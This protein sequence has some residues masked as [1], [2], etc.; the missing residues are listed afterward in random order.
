MPISVVAADRFSPYSSGARRAA[1]VSTQQ[2][3]ERALG[4]RYQI[5]RLLGWGAAGIVY[6]AR[7]RALHRTVVLKLL[8]PELSGD[9][10]ARER[11][12]REARTTAQLTHPGIVPVHAFGELEPADGTARKHPLLYMV[13]SYVG[14]GS[15]ADRLATGHPLPPAELRRLLVDLAAALEYAHREGVVH[16]DVKPENVLLAVD[17]AGA[18]PRPVLID[19][20]VAAFPTRDAGPAFAAMAAGTPAFMAPEQLLGDFELDGRSDVYALGAIGYLALAGQLPEAFPSARTPLA[21]LAPAAPADLVAAIERCLAA[22]PGERWPSAAALG[23]ALVAGAG[24]P[25]SVRARVHAGTRRARAA[26]DTLVRGARRVLGLTPRPRA[27]D[28]LR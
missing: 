14:G 21:A 6:L 26:F 25:A 10:R 4:D 23:A 1:P 19:F 22:E 28:A 7:E 24:A 11:F 9:A 20:G 12:R 15:L 17:G 13:M 8:R 5:V 3:V 16:R 18:A 27:L 2:L